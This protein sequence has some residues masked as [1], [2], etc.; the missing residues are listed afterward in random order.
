M[1]GALKPTKLE[2]VGTVGRPVGRRQC[3]GH[4]VYF[5][6]SSKLEHYSKQRLVKSLLVSAI[7]GMIFHPTL[8]LRLRYVGLSRRSWPALPKAWIDRPAPDRYLVDNWLIMICA[9]NC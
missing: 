5:H 8:L 1:F 6:S 7:G 3:K 4:N 9:S 2:P